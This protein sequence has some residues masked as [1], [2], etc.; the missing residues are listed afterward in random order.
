MVYS[1]EADT[2]FLRVKVSGRDTD[3]PPSDLCALIFAESEKRG[4]RRILIELDQQFPLSSTSQ[5]AL[6]TRLP[7]IGF[8]VDHR[9][10]LV[11]R[12]SE[13]RKSN[14]FINVVASNRGVMVRNFPGLQ[15]AESWLR[16]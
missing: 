10:A 12:T 16:E 1:I 6:V 13:A 5:Y 9:I 15:D 3:R 14:D 8:T 4:R 11:H 7:E 2:E